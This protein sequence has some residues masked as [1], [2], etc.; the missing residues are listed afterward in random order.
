[1]LQPDSILEDTADEQKL[2]AAFQGPAGWK[3]WAVIEAQASTQ[4]V[5]VR[6][7]YASDIWMGG[8]GRGLHCIRG[9]ISPEVCADPL[10]KSGSRSG[11][12]L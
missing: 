10:L 12:A 4:S 8:T 3:P 5:I 7:G 1:M 11:A 2:V 9:C 6:W